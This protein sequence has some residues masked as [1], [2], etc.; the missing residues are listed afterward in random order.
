MGCVCVCWEG[1][2]RA[3]FILLKVG[4][5]QMH[6]R[7]VIRCLGRDSS[8]RCTWTGCRPGRRTPRVSRHH[9]AS[10]HPYPSLVGWHVGPGV[11]HDV[12]LLWLP[13]LLYQV[14]PPCKGVTPDAIFYIV[15]WR[16]HRV[17]IL[18]RSCSS[19]MAKLQN[20]CGTRLVIQNMRVRC[21]IFFYY[22]V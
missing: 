16:L 11:D 12:H 13:R 9:L 1:G 15:A 10:A 19:E 18:F 20:N 8:S 7:K 2:E 22:W 4:S 3:L 21:V 14:G 17:F 5:R 6:T